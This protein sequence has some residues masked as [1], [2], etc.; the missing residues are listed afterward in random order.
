MTNVAQERAWV[1]HLILGTKILRWLGRA[2]RFYLAHNQTGWDQQ[3]S[4]NDLTNNGQK[5]ILK[6]FSLCSLD[7]IKMT[8]N[9]IWLWENAT[10]DNFFL[11][12]FLIRHVNHLTVEWFDIQSLWDSFGAAE[13][14]A[15]AAATAVEWRYNLVSWKLDYFFFNLLS[16]VV[17]R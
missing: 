12:I 6:C 15:S 11:C 3:F 10:A 2:H 9:R 8:L 7:C 5:Q 14:A 16:H 1:A 4:G 13:T 17:D